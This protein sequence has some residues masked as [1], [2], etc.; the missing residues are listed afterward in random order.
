[1]LL[2]P[3][4]LRGNRPFDEHGF[5]LLEHHL[6][7]RLAARRRHNVSSHKGHDDHLSS[8]KL[9]PIAKVTSVAAI[10]SR[11]P[12]GS[13]GCARCS[14]SFQRSR[15]HAPAVGFA[16]LHV[17]LRVWDGCGDQRVV[18]AGAEGEGRDR[19]GIR[20]PGAPDGQD[21]ERTRQFT[22]ISRPREPPLTILL[23]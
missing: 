12:W 20:A 2:L 18:C 1:D 19:I 21:S 10:P 4:L 14:P 9:R 6:E 11:W 8:G 17:A 22:P 3:L 16:M 15:R 13:G 7:R 23:L 5:T